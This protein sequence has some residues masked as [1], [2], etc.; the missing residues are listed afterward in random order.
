M[1]DDKFE[2][3][4]SDNGNA[5][6]VFDTGCKVNDGSFGVIGIAW[7]RDL[8][9][10]LLAVPEHDLVRPARAIRIVKARY[11]N[12]TALFSDKHICHG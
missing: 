3:I 12:L 6:M 11:D 1:N 9:T 10:Y 4:R 8:P 2:D 7:C 5:Q